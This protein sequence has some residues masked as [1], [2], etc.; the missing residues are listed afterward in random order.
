MEIHETW[1]NLVAISNLRKISF[2]FPQIRSNR[3]WIGA[4]LHIALLSDI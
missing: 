2:V 3:I 4:E 1:N